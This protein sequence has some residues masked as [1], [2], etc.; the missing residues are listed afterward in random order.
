[1]EMLGDVL[2]GNLLIAVGKHVACWVYLLLV[3]TALE[4]L[5]SVGSTVFQGSVRLSLF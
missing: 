3:M 2:V 1:M 4:R 5:F